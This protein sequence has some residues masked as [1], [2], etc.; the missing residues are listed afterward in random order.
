MLG[1]FDV[2]DSRAAADMR[3]AVMVRELVAT[4]IRGLTARGGHGKNSAGLES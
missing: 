1:Q 4:S 2:A 3:Q